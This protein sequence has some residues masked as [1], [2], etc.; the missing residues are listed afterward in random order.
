MSALDA[1]IAACVGAEIIDF[2]EL[3]VLAGRVA[4]GRAQ[5]FHALLLHRPV[6][7]GPPLRLGGRKFTHCQ[8]PRQRTHGLESPIIATHQR[9][10][11]STLQFTREEQR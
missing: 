11:L 7:F 10:L 4:P 1:G 6:L 9:A 2:C 5:L 3:R 8:A